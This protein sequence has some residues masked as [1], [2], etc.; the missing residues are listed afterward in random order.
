MCKHHTLVSHTWIDLAGGSTKETVA[1]YL[2]YLHL[3]Q[4]VVSQKYRNVSEIIWYSDGL[5]AEKKW[6]SGTCERW[7]DYCLSLLSPIIMD[8]KMEEPNLARHQS[9]LSQSLKK[10][11]GW[12]VEQS[13]RYLTETGDQKQNNVRIT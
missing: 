5:Y 11:S 9:E 4:I 12:Y 7:T 1:I 10:K 3:I 6:K 8:D 2:I 13:K